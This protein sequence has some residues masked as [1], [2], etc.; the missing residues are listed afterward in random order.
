MTRR[1]P[2]L[3]F[4]SD[5]QSAASL[6]PESWSLL[7]AEAR[8]CGLMARVASELEIQ[9]CV[10]MPAG[11]ASHVLAASRQANSFVEDV[12]R[13]LRLIDR[14]LALLDARVIY[15]KGAAYVA[16]GLPAARGR[17][18]SDVDLLVERQH[19]ADAEGALMLSGWVAHHLSDYDR[20]YYR[21]WSH[22]VPPMVHLQRGTTID[23]HH[24]LV[25][26]TCRI[27][28]DVNRMIIE[29]VAIPGEGNRF[30]LKDEDLVLHAAS[31]LLLNSEFDKG[32]RDLWDID[33]LLRHFSVAKPDFVVR[34]LNRAAEVGLTIIVRRAFALCHRLFGT[35]IPRQ[36]LA[37]GGL[38]MRLLEKATSTRHPD[39]RPRW[40]ALADEFLLLRE[41]NL[42]LPPHL[43]VRHLWHKIT[44]SRFDQGDR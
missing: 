11:L 3:D 2:L 38:V 30:R 24:S 15:L 12:G 44:N 35:R 10:S 5:R 40:Q 19:L 31:H 16:A 6:D 7:F 42:R 28:V 1:S 39:T 41:L 21:E 20:R 32:M 14:A 34:V 13:E 27:R 43:L 36:V 29:A 4:L 37:E 9:P 23:L 17:V 8:A 22:E 26:P 18:F 25:M 33:L